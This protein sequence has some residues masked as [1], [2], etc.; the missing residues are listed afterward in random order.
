[1]NIQIP[2]PLAF[3]F[4]TDKRYV[5][6]HGGRGSGKS[7]SVARRLILRCCEEKRRVLCAR[8]I[9]SS[10]AESVHRTIA[11]EISAMGLD[12]LFKVEQSMIYG[13]N[14]SEFLFKGLRFNITE[15]KST[16]GITDCWI[17]EAN[18]VSKTSFETL[19]P[20]IREPKSQIFIT[21]NAELEEDY[22]YDRFVVKGDPD[23]IVRQVNWD[24][25][26]FFPEVLER[27]RLAHKE[28]D[29]DGYLTT[30]EGHPR[31]M[32]EGAVFAREMR[33]ATEEG[34]ITRVPYDMSKPVD[35]FWDFGRAD[36]TSIWFGQVFGY[37]FRLI[38]FYE[39][40]G[41]AIGGHIKA[42]Q[43]KP[44]VY[45]TD[46][47]PHDG[48]N[49]DIRHPESLEMQ[50]RGLGRKVKVL[51]RIPNMA[52]GINASRTVFPRCVFDQNKCADGLHH[53][54]RWRFKVNENGSYSKEPDHDEHSH[55]AKAFESMARGLHVPPVVQRKTVQLPAQVGGWMSR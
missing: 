41:M 26:P 23:A 29:P 47:V 49:K 52:E 11:D 24:Q 40:N 46:Y 14:G 51:S 44:Y 13:P 15:I 7:I 39:D 45:G 53:L 25:N 34:R 42:L 22:I 17:E 50:M 12:P 4:E 31:Q 30:W 55:A 3:L 38:D 10:I 37:E 6:A 16:K 27:L 9:Q 36:M 35:T 20:T 18:I 1:M 33:D 8:E 5:I 28:R 2:D 32:L 43:A 21:F 54:R 19:D 48:G